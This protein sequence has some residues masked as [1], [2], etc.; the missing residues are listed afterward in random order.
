[1][2]LSASIAFTFAL[3]LSASRM[4]IRGAPLNTT[5]AAPGIQACSGVNGTGDCVSLI[6]SEVGGTGLCNNVVAKSLVMADENE[7]VSF[8]DVDCEAGDL[9]PREFFSDN[10]GDLP[11]GINSWICI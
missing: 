2:F 10:S 3:F 8:G 7:C 5:A 11:D 9:V 1:M 4:A 6:V